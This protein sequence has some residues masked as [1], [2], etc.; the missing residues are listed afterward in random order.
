MSLSNLLTHHRGNTLF[1]PAHGRGNALP[2]EIKALLKRK[3][4]LWDLPELPDIGGPT[5]LDGAVAKSQEESALTVGAKKGW[6]GVN[7]ATGLLQASIL[8]IA[9]PKESVLMPRNI[10]RSVI[11][12]CILGDIN[13]VLFDLPFLIDRG[14]YLPPDFDWFKTVL[15]RLEV[16]KVEISAVVLSNPTYQGY[17]SD[18]K[19]LI[20]LIH[21]KG[22]PV[23]VDEAHGAHFATCIGDALPKSA[24][25][26]GADLVVH[27]LHKSSLG[28]VQTA[29]LWWQGN[30][31]DPEILER[32]IVLL[33]TTSP[34]ALLMASCEAAVNE[35]HSPL[36][37]KKLKELLN[38]SKQLSSSLIAAGLPI[39]ENQDPLRLV[40][41]TSSFG[42]C[43]LDADKWFI[44][45]GIIAELPEP[46]TITFCLGFS[47]HRGLVR[48]LKRRW[49]QLLSSDISINFNPPF[50]KPPFPFVSTPE[51]S[52]FS[53]FRS[54]SKII[55]LQ[56]SVG[57]ISSDL[58]SPYP[59][60]IPIILPGE[61]LDKR[62]VDWMMEQQNFWSDQIPT[63][64]KVVA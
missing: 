33:Q 28:L 39:L 44:D 27:S 50:K 20:D 58:I 32:S 41:H 64:I 57:K 12:A 2:M 14:H 53:A 6:Y 7:G 34:S 18:L 54:K 47:R 49:S 48:T 16:E 9:R 31:I 55:P 35:L 36:G 59:P 3:P 30:L 24:L 22:W 26:A 46:G 13:P 10:H 60:G 52:C 62:R 25:H 56:E 40:L 43:G 4:G 17:S 8:A 5:F 37:K 11:Q 23:L 63:E 61:K 29:V 51:K 45:K 21:K 1:L 42:I 15:E 38:D 19:P